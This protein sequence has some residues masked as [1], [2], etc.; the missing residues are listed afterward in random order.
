ML[1]QE[2]DRE[3]MSNQKEAENQM[4]TETESVRFLLRHPWKMM[5]AE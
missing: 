4:A 1:I 5:T 2:Q 3:E